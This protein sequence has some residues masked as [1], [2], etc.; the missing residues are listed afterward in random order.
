MSDQRKGG[1]AWTN[2]TWN[3]IRGCSIV[4]AEC[5][6]CYAM[7]KAHQYGGHG[8]PYDGLTKVVN[9]RALWNGEVRMIPEHLTDPIRWKR[10]RLVF[11]NSMSD[12][13]H[14][15][16]TFEQIA[17]IFGVMA[18]AWWHT[19][20]VLTKRD[21]RMLEFFEW[22]G[23][24]ESTPLATIIGETLVE[25]PAAAKPPIDG[26]AMEHIVSNGWPLKHVWLGVSVG[27][28]RAYKRVA[29]LRLAPA[30]VR[31]ISMEPQIENLD[32]IDLTGMDWIVQGG[33]SASVQRARVFN[34]DWARS[35]RKKCLAADVPFFFKQA[36]TVAWDGANRT[37]ADTT[38]KG[39]KPE[40]WPAEIRVR[41]W[42]KG[43]AA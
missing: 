15:K 8:M 38:G 2:E 40:E 37:A 19:Y 16:L 25:N 17:Q 11:V 31:W 5:A 20:Q 1:I 41:E 24:Q 12:I 26:T 43:W 27:E 35:M 23:R 28:R 7:A 33:E 36:G 21:E 18:I 13:F 39:D 22:L 3:P 34:L 4:S 32:D 10:P 29:A 30:A 14:E 6:N 9:G 42:P